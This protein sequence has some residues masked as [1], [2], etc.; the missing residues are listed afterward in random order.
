[1][2]RV[3]VEQ[4][5]RHGC[6]V[7]GEDLGTVPDGFRPAL[8]ERGIW[9]YRVMLFEREHDGRFRPPEHYPSNALATFATHDLATF[10]G[11][12]TGHDL[13]VK[14]SIGID[15]GETDEERART[16][17]ALREA[18]ARY[19]NE[20]D[21]FVAIVRYLADTPSR[22]VAVAAEDIWSSADQIN[23]P[24]TV[25]EHPNWRHRLPVAVEDMA[26]DARLWQIAAAFKKAGR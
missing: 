15:P 21:D 7:I 6:I 18:L 3:I 1:M 14:R 4:S 20:D 25:R 24:G 11:W 22:L 19:R 8:S 16:H 5:D 9:T 17:A 13:R 12:S 26:N 10:A 23:I 2:L